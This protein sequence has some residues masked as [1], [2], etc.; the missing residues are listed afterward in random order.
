[1]NN[2]RFIVGCGSFLPGNP[3]SNEQMATHLGINNPRQLRVGRKILRQNGIRQRHYALDDRGQ[4]THLNEELAVHAIEAALGNAGVTLPDIE[5]LAWGSSTPDVPV[6]GIASMIHGRMQSQPMEVASMAGLCG[7]GMAALKTA[8]HNIG[9][10]MKLTMAG[11][12]ECAGRVVRQCLQQDTS[13][14]NRKQPISSFE[15]EFLQWML[16]DGA[17]AVV[18]S[19]RPRDKGLSLKID[20]IKSTSYAGEYPPC[21]Y[22]GLANKNNYAAGD[23]WLDYPSFALAEQ[24]GLTQLRQDTRILQNIVKVG[25]EELLRLTENGQIDTTTVD[26]FL[27]HYSSHFFRSEVLSNLTEAGILIPESKWFTNLYNKGNTGAASIFI[28]LDE[29]LHTHRFKLGEQILLMV[30]ESGRFMISTAMLTVVDATTEVNLTATEHNDT[31]HNIRCRWQTQKTKT[32]VSDSNPASPLGAELEQSPNQIVQWLARELTHVWL[33]FERM[34][35]ATPI[36]QR[37]ETG[38]LNQQDYRDLLCNLRQQVVDGARWIAR[39]SSSFEVEY[40]ELRA[41]ILHHAVDEHRDFTMLEKNYVAVG[42]ELATIQNADKN[43]GSEALSAFIF[44]RASQPNPI[45]LLGAM[46]VIEGLGKTKVGQWASMIQ[47]QLQLNKTQVSFML[48]HQ[49]NDEHHFEKL[50]QVIQSGLV[51]QQAARKIVKTAKT[52]ARLY[53]LQLEELNYV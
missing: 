30:P 13:D 4:A 38:Q 53:A 32:T 2:N 11:A 10:G 33:D 41:L 9:A 28:M 44:H 6:P 50:R 1:M 51:D 19:D 18:L 15:G 25:V 12:S 34:L 49:D 20:W 7:S 47:Q 52:V 35:S 21:M 29:A 3:I 26:H 5:A 46:F 40:F 48:Y 14:H 31:T 45:D 39:A 43:I 16:S 27:L 36:I 23:S 17:G 24:Q 37:L 22:Y 8:W 42:G